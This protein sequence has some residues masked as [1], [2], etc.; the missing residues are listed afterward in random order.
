MIAKTNLA[1]DAFTAFK[2]AIV[3]SIKAL[4]DKIQA[5]IDLLNGQFGGG[6]PKMPP[7]TPPIGT[8]PTP[9]PG[10]GNGGRDDWQYDRRMASSR[11]AST[12]VTVNIAGSLVGQRDLQDAVVE[13]VNAASSSGTGPGFSRIS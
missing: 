7:P 4:I 13:A 8:P 2:D 3:A 10:Y 1:S 11:G 9:P 12:N 5:Q 6:A